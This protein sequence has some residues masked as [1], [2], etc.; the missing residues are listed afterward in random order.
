MGNFR[1]QDYA[2]VLVKAVETMR[3]SLGKHIF[4]EANIVGLEEFPGKWKE[5]SQVPH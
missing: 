3:E 5:L 4:P 2:P 1:T